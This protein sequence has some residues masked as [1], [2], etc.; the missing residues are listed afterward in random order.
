[1]ICVVQRVSAAEV[2]VGGKS[3]G[4][5]GKGLVVL[6]AIVKEDTETDFTWVANKLASLRIFPTEKG[7]YDADV[8]T[9]G[10]GLLLVSNFTVAAQTANGRRPGFSNAMPPDLARPAFDRFVDIV[11]T[12]GVTVQTGEFGADMLVR[13]ENDGPVTV[14][15][16]SK[17]R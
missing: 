10:G 5:I 13:I 3:I 2:T 9:I 12:T 1:M 11:R 8:K 17:N 6:A 15:V 4:K 14:I 7:A 16:D